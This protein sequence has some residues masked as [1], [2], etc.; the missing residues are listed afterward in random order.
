VIASALVLAATL[1]Q[2]AGLHAPAS[3]SASVRIVGGKDTS[4]QRLIIL[5]DMGNEPDEEQQNAHLLV[6]C[7]EFD[8]EAMICVTGKYLRETAVEEYKRHL[9]PE[10]YHR[11]IDGY[12]KVLPNLKLHAGGWPEADYL[13]SIVF[14]G[15]QRYGLAD[16]GEG[17]ASPGSKAIIQA[18]LKEDPR[19]VWVV[20]NAGANTLAQALW[21]LRTRFKDEPAKLDTLV[22]KLR[23]FENGAQDNTGAWI[24]H[25]FPKIHWI[26]SNYQTYAYGGP[27]GRDGGLANGLGPHFWKPYPYTVEG[28]HQ[29]LKEY[30]QV[31]HGALGEL[32]P[33]RRFGGGNLGFMEGGGTV[34]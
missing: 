20:V 16:V 32:Y 24:C 1:V 26:R 22:A 28:Q 7:N 33:D 19:P 21:D 30:V 17:K 27:G 9:H 6:C 34:P 8:I 3:Q 13:H 4:R 2:A 10:L 15:Q 25:E 12:A 29:W 18:L 11:L 14:E 31:G 5:A 23:V